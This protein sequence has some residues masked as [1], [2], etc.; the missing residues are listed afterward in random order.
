MMICMFKGKRREIGVCWV[1]NGD[2]GYYCMDIVVVV[3]WFRE[4]ISVCPSNM[5]SACIDN[6]ILATYGI[7]NGRI[8]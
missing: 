4:G 3:F 7:G 6:G 1:V 8:I 2:K 5:L